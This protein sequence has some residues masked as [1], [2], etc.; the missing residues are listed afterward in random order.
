MTEIATTNTAPVARDPLWKRA[1]GFVLRW[2]YRITG[3]TI[4]LA[5]LIVLLAQTDMVRSFMRTKVIDLVNEQ[6]EGKL[7]FDEVRLDI[8]RGI[9]LEHPQLHAHGTTVL[10]AERLEITYELAALFNRTIAISKVVLTRPHIFVIRSAD[11]VWN[12]ERIVK[13]DPDTTTSAPPNLTI[14]VRDFSIIEGTLVVDDRTSKRGDGS[15]FDPLHLSLKALELRAAVRLALG[16][17]DY[18]VA[19]NHLSFYDEFAKTLDVR[20]LTLAARIQPSGVDLQSL[21]IKLVNTDLEVRARI[22]GLDVLRDGISDSLLELHPIV[23][24][25]E[26]RR[27]WGPDLRFFIPDIDVTDAYAIKAHVSYA[28]KHMEIDDIDL[29]AGDGHILGSVKLTQLDESDNLG[30]DI[31]VY[32]SHARYADVRRRLRFVELPELTFL[33]K[34]IIESAHL[35]GKPSQSLSFDVHGQDSPGRFDGKMTLYLAEKR[36]GYNVD[37]KVRHGDISVFADSS[38]ATQINGHVLMRGKGLTLQDLEGVYQV[39]LDRSIVSGRPVRRA[40]ILAHANGAGQIKLDTL[41]AD[42]TPFRRDTID[43]YA[44]TPDDRLVGA[45]GTIDARDKDHPKYAGTLNLSA[46]D[47]AGFFEN[48]S[49]PKRITGTIDVNAEG[50]ELDS[51]FGT[52]KADITEFSLSDRALMPFV[53]TIESSRQGD[54]RSVFINAP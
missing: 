35:R 4:I 49:L 24:D 32:N 34:T 51:I 11:S 38:F 31:K 43:E 3:V 15:T 23:G 47:L 54:G 28:G 13:P 25:L 39:D 5:A 8:F 20:T 17:K 19:V 6:L 33:H 37:M 44:L 40:R 10:E 18:S 16:D 2:I 48:P 29:W 50:I 26:T 7:T 45:S 30:V 36:L 14:R 12:I 53:L 41:F 52:M 27:V 42:V 9:V 21:S 1:A 46:M 22:D